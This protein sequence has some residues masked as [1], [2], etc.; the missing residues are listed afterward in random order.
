LQI[1]CHQ[2][3]EKEKAQNI[4]ERLELLKNN[5]YKLPVIPAEKFFIIELL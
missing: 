4:K 2:H 3:N 5:T 1:Y